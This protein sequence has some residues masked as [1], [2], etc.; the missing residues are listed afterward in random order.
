MTTDIP[1]QVRMRRCD[2]AVDESGN[3]PN[4]SSRADHD[5]ISSRQCGRRIPSPRHSTPRW[6]A[7][8]NFG[9]CSAAVRDGPGIVTPDK[10]GGAYGWRWKRPSQ[11][12]RQAGFDARGGS[13]ARDLRDCRAGAGDENRHRHAGIARVQRGELRKRR[14]L[15]NAGRACL[16]RARSERSAQCDHPGHQARAAQWTR[17][18]RVYGFV[19]AGEADRHVEVEPPD[20]A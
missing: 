15:R 8:P 11:G 3:R 17:N 1:R 19:S 10:L 6:R 7:M 13:H 2:Q 16:W 18:G 4:A 12:C 14:P 9:Y 5:D 20:V